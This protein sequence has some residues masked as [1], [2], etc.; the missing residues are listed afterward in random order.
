MRAKFY[1]PI[2]LCLISTG[3]SEPVKV[4]STKYED[5]WLAFDKV[6]HF[7]FSFLWTLSSQYVLVNNMNMYEHDALR[8]SVM[9]SLSAG[10]MKETYDMKQPNGYFSNKDMVANGLGILLAVM[11]M[12]GNLLPE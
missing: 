2:F 1:F 6:Q 5:K 10:I 3:I 12:N 11:I 9:S 8:C 4:D 7:T